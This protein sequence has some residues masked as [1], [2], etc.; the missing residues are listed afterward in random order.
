MIKKQVQQESEVREKMR[1]GQGMVKIRHHVKAGDVKGKCRLCAQLTLSAGA[2]IGLHEH[3][4]EDEIFIVQQG[5][6]L[7]NDNG[8][9][10]PVEAGD[11]IVTG[12]GASHAVQNIGTTDL[13]ITAV[14]IQH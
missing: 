10:V 8:T 4:G 6:G 5:M 7:V 1:G 13:I 11:V 3:A 2:S 9:S 12:N 14:I